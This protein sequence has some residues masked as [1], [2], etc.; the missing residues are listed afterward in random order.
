MQSDDY[1]GP[2]SARQLSWILYGVC[3]LY[4]SVEDNLSDYLS[5][6]KDVKDGSLLEELDDLNLEAWLRGLLQ[7]SVAFMA[8]IRAGY[9]PYRFFAGEDFSRV[10]DFNTNRT[11]S[12]LGAAAS[13]IGQMVIREIEVTVRNLE[14]EEKRENRTFAGAQNN[15][16]DNS[17]NQNT[18]RSSE[19]GADLYDAG[20]LSDARPEPAGE[21]ENWEVWNAAAALPARAPERDLHRD[22][23]GRDTEQP[24]G[25]SGRAGEPDA[26]KADGAVESAERGDRANESG[27]S[28]EVGSDDERNPELRGGDNPERSDLQLTL[29]TVEEQ[30]NIIQEAEAETCLLYTSRCV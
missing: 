26:G 2:D 30:Q 6:L 17:R 20:R 12:I 28:D 11:I 18:E 7:D 14:K 9:D 25:R 23:A 3:L 15:R 24:S 29:P 1:T 13:D 19:Y 27:R 4:T 5:Q 21:P 22:D 16:Y 8:L 10:Y